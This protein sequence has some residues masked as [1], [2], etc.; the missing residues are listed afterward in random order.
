M[1]LLFDLDGT[2]TDSWPGIVRCINHALETLGHA[3]VDATRLRR[4]IGAPLGRILPALLGSDDPAVIDRAIAAYRA[5]FTAIGMFENRLYEGVP[6][7]LRAFEAAGHTLH[8]VTA[9]PTAAAVRVLEHFGLAGLFTSVQGSDPHDH[10]CDKAALLRAALAVNGAD[11]RSAVMI[12]DRAEDV[13]AARANDAWSVAAL[14]GYGSKDELLAERPDSVAEHVT[15]VIRWV[16][17][18]H[19]TPRSIA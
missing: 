19:R 12:G 8:V 11:A 1:T 13:R 7:A 14:W 6:D 15:D 4:M 3:P 9:K 2:L 17:T 10:D 16:R 5:R 18:K